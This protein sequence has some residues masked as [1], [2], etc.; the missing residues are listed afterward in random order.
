MIVVSLTSWKARIGNVKKVV[1]YIMKNTVQPDRVYLNLSRDEW[2]GE[3]LPKDLIEYFYSDE[4]LVINWVDGP[5]TKPFKK[6]FPILRYL[7]DED[8]IM[9]LDDDMLPAVL[10]E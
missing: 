4:R 7:D 3:P 1:E 8:I 2:E 5:D 10:I 6:V 9:T